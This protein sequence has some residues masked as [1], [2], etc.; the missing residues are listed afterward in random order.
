[1]IT[2][3]MAP[4][5]NPPEVVLGLETV[6]PETIG[7]PEGTPATPQELAQMKQMLARQQ[8][9]GH[10]VPGRGGPTPEAPP[11]GPLPPPGGEK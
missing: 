4:P 1:M 8:R 11:L 10:G 9:G 5:V 3:E 2:P 7:A 6:Q